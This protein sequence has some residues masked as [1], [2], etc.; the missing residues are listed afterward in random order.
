MQLSDIILVSRGLFLLQ[1]YTGHPPLPAWPAGLLKCKKYIFINH[2]NTPCAWTGR[3]LL[4]R[5]TG[6][7]SPVHT[8]V[9][10]GIR[11]VRVVPAPLVYWQVSGT[12]RMLQM[13]LCRLLRVGVTSGDP[14]CHQN[15]PKSQLGISHCMYNFGV[16]PSLKGRTWST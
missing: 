6:P 4:L 11:K 3:G 7:D 15:S 2:E 16:D 9:Q 8:L 1:T 5:M 13:D 10:S 12:L 14:P